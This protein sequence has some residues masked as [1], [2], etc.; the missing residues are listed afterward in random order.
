MNLMRIPFPHD[1]PSRRGIKVHATQHPL[2]EE[3]VY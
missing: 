2:P 3:L 1:T